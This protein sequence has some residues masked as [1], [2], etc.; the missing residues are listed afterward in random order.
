MSVELY[1][2]TASFKDGKLDA[3]RKFGGMEYSASSGEW[4]NTGAKLTHKAGLTLFGF[5]GE[6]GQEQNSNSS[7]YKS[8]Y[9][10]GANESGFGAKVKHETDSSGKE[11]TSQQ[12]EWTIGIKFIIALELKL[13]IGQ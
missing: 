8:Y 1:K 4:D 3:T 13:S 11:S 7:D 5:G 9:E 12:T 2:E 10:T 6:I